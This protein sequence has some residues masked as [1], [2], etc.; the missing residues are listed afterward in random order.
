[1]KK[2]L[3]P[4]LCRTI[5]PKGETQDILDAYPDENGNP[6]HG[7]IF[8][9]SPSGK[10]TWVAR[11]KRG[12]GYATRRLGVFPQMS[13][14]EAREEYDRLRD[15]GGFDRA[16]LNFRQLGKKYVEEYARQQLRTWDQDV[17]YLERAKHLDVKPIDE[18]RRA[19]VLALLAEFPDSPATAV[20]VLARVRK[21]LQWAVDRGMIEYNPAVG[22][23]PPRH[24]RKP[25][26]LLK[27]PQLVSFLRN[28]PTAKMPEIF[29][30]ILLFQLL[31]GT[32]ISETLNLA[33]EELDLAR[34]EWHLPAAR[35]K[36]GL[37]HTVY[38]S[39]QAQEV[40][41]QLPGDRPFAAAAGRFY[42]AREVANYLAMNRQHLGVPAAYTSHG[43]RHTLA[44]W[45]A[46]RGYSREVRDRVLA[47]RIGD[48]IDALYTHHSYDDEAKRAWYQWGEHLWALSQENVVPISLAN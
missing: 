45:L 6:R 41:G 15:A 22:I 37:P 38:L 48:G 12:R 11:L 28:L 29:R 43:A 35:S 31:T 33:A 14:K 21:V 20:Q 27:P 30:S 10:R 36:N 8:R 1:M 47:H 40:L 4:V 26:P 2:I 32:R 3:T 39:P 9:I 17:Y 19:D 7:F 25:P 42:N 44:T 18:I 5:R 24:Q 46:G 23:K 16:Q 34:G 13:L